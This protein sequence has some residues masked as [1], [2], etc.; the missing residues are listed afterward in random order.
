[1]TDALPLPGDARYLKA[2]LS[3]GRQLIDP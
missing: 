1:M 3:S 2:G